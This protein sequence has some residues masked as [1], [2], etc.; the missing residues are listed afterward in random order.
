MTTRN[1]GQRDERHT[2]RQV[3]R[4]RFGAGH[5]SLGESLG[6]APGYGASNTWSGLRQAEEDAQNATRYRPSEYD[7]YDY[8]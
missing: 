6:G 8:G 1:G 3:H 2:N 4:E 5:V 7:D